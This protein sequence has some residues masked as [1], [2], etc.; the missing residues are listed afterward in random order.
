MDQNNRNNET[1]GRS[2]YALPTLLARGAQQV[3]SDKMLN[4]AGVCTKLCVSRATVYAQM[5][6]DPSF[7]RPLKIG[8]KRVCW[9]E[10]ALDTWLAQCEAA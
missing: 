3:F 8:P 2:R 10:S 1:A 9:R 7:P 4:I 6:R 5:S